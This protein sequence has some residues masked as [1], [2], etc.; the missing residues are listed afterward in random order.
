MTPI[1]PVEIELDQDAEQLMIRPLL[2]RRALRA[3]LVV[4]AFPF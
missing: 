1:Q 3:C 4:Q 2:S